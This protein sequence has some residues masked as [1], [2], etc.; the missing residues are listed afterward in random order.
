LKLIND[1]SKVIE[2]GSTIFRIGMILKNRK[3]LSKE[4]LENVLI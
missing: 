3:E 4:W 2:S 1:F